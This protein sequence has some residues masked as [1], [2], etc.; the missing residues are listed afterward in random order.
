MAGVV[1]KDSILPLTPPTSNRSGWQVDR[2]GRIF[3]RI[4]PPG[5]TL[6]EGRGLA[7]RERLAAVSFYEGPA[8]IDTPYSI[9][10]CYPQRKHYYHMRMEIVLMPTWAQ[11]RSPGFQRTLDTWIHP[12]PD[13][14]F[15]EGA[16]RYYHFYVSICNIFLVSCPGQKLTTRDYLSFVALL[17][18]LLPHTHC[19]TT[20][21]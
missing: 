19:A 11:E 2:Y 10:V 3:A 8:S 20:P 12:Y 5:E 15:P 13:E 1:P 7:P 4:V 18:P 14:G 17:P 16:K 21:V 9:E 6:W